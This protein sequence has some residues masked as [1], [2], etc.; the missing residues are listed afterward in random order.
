MRTA[1]VEFKEGR[2]DTIMYDEW[3]IQGNA[4]VFKKVAGGGAV[5]SLDA[6]LRADLQ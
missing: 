1:T 3:S 2:K 5:I 4:L 6:V